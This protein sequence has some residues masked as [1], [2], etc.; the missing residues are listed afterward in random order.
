MAR[1][2]AALSSLYGYPKFLADGR[3]NQEPPEDFVHRKIGEDWS[4]QV[5]LYERR[6][7]QE[8]IPVPVDPV[9]RKGKE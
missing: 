7:A 1:V 5:V 4:R 8:E 3:P 6:R 2:I 9:I